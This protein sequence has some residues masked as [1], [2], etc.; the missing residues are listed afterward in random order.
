MG[1][2][3]ANIC[4]PTRQDNREARLDIELLEADNA[5]KGEGRLHGNCCIYGRESIEYVLCSLLLHSKGQPL[6]KSTAFR[7]SSK[8]SVPT[9]LSSATLLYSARWCQR[10]VLLSLRSFRQLLLFVCQIDDSIQYEHPL[11]A[12]RSVCSLPLSMQIR[13]SL[14]VLYHGKEISFSNCLFSPS[15]MRWQVSPVHPS[16]LH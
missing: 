8:D 4:M 1:T 12:D 7:S 6:S 3:V 13:S 5:V 15:R 9:T 11:G 16:N 10:N 14:D 2:L